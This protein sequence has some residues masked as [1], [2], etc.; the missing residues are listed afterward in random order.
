M[1]FAQFP[2]ACGAM[3]NASAYGEMMMGSRRF[4]V[5]SLVGSNIFCI[6]NLKFQIIIISFKILTCDGRE[7]NPG[8]LLGRQPC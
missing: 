5:R 4:Q 7:S 1:A 2:R 6:V 8:R 3:D